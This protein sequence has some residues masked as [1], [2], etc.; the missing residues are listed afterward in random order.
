[1]RGGK[2]CL[3]DSPGRGSD[4]SSKGSQGYSR[5]VNRD[6]L[7]QDDEPTM[8]TTPGT[9]N[10]LD[11]NTSSQSAI[12]VTGVYIDELTRRRE[13]ALRQHAFFQ[14]RLHIRRGANLVAMDRCGNFYN[15]IRIIYIQF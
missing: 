2:S 9:I 1:M 13:L 10:I 12:G 7:L 4:G 6:I 5:G 15:F 14:L 11:N 3:E 8:S